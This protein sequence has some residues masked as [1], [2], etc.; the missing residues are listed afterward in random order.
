LQLASRYNILGL[1]STATK[2]LLG[3]N[4]FGSSFVFALALRLSTLSSPTKVLSFL[5]TP[6]PDPHLFDP[7]LLFLAVSAIPL[8]AFL[9]QIGVWLRPS[10]TSRKTVLGST[11]QSPLVQESSRPS[12]RVHLP[13]LDHDDRWPCHSDAG[14][15]KRVLIGA[16]LFGIGWGI[17]GIC[18]ESRL[19]LRQVTCSCL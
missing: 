7:T 10:Q 9:F 12:F 4:I 1:S 5:I 19:A 3:L 2:V 18:R 17:E 11:E 15:D 16:I 6:F 13:I 8:A 14:V